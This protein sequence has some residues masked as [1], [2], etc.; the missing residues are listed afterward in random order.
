[1]PQNLVDQSN[2][3]KIVYALGVVK[4]LFVQASLERHVTMKR[5][6]VKDDCVVVAF[7]N[8]EGKKAKKYSLEFPIGPNV[9][10]AELIVRSSEN[11]ALPQRTNWLRF[12][13]WTD[14]Q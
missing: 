2:L 14:L 8:G 10:D 11:S 13:N 6:Y 7:A 9:L 4:H 1:M 5:V 12:V 3:D